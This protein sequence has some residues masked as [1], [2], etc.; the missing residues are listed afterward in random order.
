MAVDTRSTEAFVGQ[1]LGDL[2]ASYGGVMISIGHKLGLYRALAGRGPT[3]A[4]ELAARTGCEVRYVR[5]WLDSQVASG[6]LAYHE[7]S[8]TYE[9]PAEY[10]PVLADTTSPVYLPAAFDVPGSMWIDQERTLQAFRTGEGVPW[11]ERDPR[12][13]CGVAGF[14]RNAYAASLVP[15][16]LPALDGVVEKL[17]RGA[18]VADVG[19]GHGHSTLLMAAAFERS[20]FVGFDTHEPSLRAAREHAEEAGVDGRVEFLSGDAASYP[21]A[22]YDLIC[23]FDC[24]HDLG[25]PV[26]AAR[27]AYEALAED[28]TLLVV[29]PFAGDTVADNLGPVGRLYYS[30]S[31]AICVPHS[32]SEGVGLALGAQAGPARLADVFREAGFTSIRHAHETPFNIVLEVRR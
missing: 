32:R 17:E 23:F 16:W 5:E 26:G 13:Q 19:C 20:R 10:V 27:R 31:T 11:G 7:E 21:G 12:L 18:R 14:Y 24:L 15:E 6:Y 2:A 4:V 29:E 22:G 1:A 28:G 9:L 25:D 30:A 3:S 8:Q